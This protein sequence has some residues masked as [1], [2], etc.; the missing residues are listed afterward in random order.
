MLQCNAA[1]R[2]DVGPAGGALH[3]R[4]ITLKWKQGTKWDEVRAGQACH[5]GAGAVKASVTKVTFRL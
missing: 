5:L 4:T 1:S 3:L 2:E